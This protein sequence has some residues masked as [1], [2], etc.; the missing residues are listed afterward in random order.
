[1]SNSI[2]YNDFR[3]M[4]YQNILIPVFKEVDKKEEKNALHHPSWTSACKPR[5]AT[6]NNIWYQ[7]GG[8]KKSITVI[9]E[10]ILD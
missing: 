7:N 2:V 9:L 1:M 6:W 5:V 8:R 10:L 3:V 4:G